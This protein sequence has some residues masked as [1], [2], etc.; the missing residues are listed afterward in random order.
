ME[1]MKAIMISNT[2]KNTLTKRDFLLRLAT[3]VVLI[4]IFIM[5]LSCYFLCQSRQQYITKVETQTQNLVIAL[6][7][8]I[9]GIIN[10]TDLTLLTLT[11]E[12]ERELNNGGIDWKTLCAL[13]DRYQP[14][15]PEIRD[16]RI[17]R[18]NGDIVTYEGYSLKILTNIADRKHF[19]ILK[20]NPNAGLVFSEPLYGRYDKKWILIAG[21]RINNPDGTFAGIVQANISIDCLVKLLSSYDLGK[22]GV[23]TLRGADLGVIARYPVEQNG[24]STIGSKIVSKQFY[25]LREKGKASATYVTPGSIDPVDRVFSYRKLNQYPLYVNAGLA[26]QDFLAD[27]RRDVFLTTSFCLLFAMVTLFSARF[28]FQKWK[29]A[30][31]SELALQRTNEH[32]EAQVLLRTSELSV[33]NSQLRNELALREKIEADLHEKAILLEAEM[34]E[35]QIMNETLQEKTIE[36]EMQIEEREAVQQSLEE[37][38]AALEDEIAERLRIEEEHSRLEEQLRQSQKIEAIGLLAGGIAHDF[39]NILSVIMGYCELLLHNLSEG[40]DHD[41]AA[42]IIKATERA[43]ELTRGLL[44]FSR[45]Q[46]FHLERTDINL[47]VAENCKFLQRVIGEDIELSA[48]YMALPLF[49]MIDRSQIQQVLMNLAT[50]ARDAMPAGG[51]LS[52]SIVSKFIDDNFIAH[53]GSG[54]PGCHAIVR[55]SDTGT[56]IAKESIERIFEPFFTTKE[57]GR[58]TGLGLSMIHGTIAQHNGF[59]LCN[60]ILGQGSTFSIY[61]PASEG[62]EN[63]SASASMDD[64]NS[65]RGSE[66]I[67]LAEDDQML[68]DVTTNN[69]EL[70]GYRVLQAHDGAECVEIFKSRADEIDLVILDAIMPKMTGKQAWEAIRS[71][72]PDVKAC[73]VSGYTNAI[74]SGKAAVDNSVPF[75]SKPVLPEKLIR[76]IRDILDGVEIAHNQV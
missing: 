56:G 25:D 10:K 8:L 50:N 63:I 41:N 32:L 51:K 68:M 26:S 23:I 49:V 14:R 55:V 72:R 37:Q 7:Q 33:A 36:L 71:V 66:T 34:A 48:T 28:V 47:L 16:I 1:N 44:A 9:S 40:K 29:R 53:H 39:N 46:N 3:G 42:Q 60:S 45:K 54:H 65:L 61:L 15:I 2:T 57:E 4:N 59:I 13:R 67:L 70:R 58:G 17:I 69:L 73:F 76:K 43:T 12:A 20:K 75:V 31:E 52:I 5:G 18:A 74:I 27:W 64:K 35:H 19:I 21:R 6:E 24:R 30:R 62:C 22:H 11:D 38:T